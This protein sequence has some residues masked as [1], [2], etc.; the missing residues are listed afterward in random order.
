MKKLLKNITLIMA[1]VMLTGCGNNIQLKNGEEVLVSFEN[2]ELS[3]TA[4]DLF[5][6]LKEDYGANYMIELIDKKILDLKYPTDETKEAYVENQIEAMETAYGGTTKFLETLQSYGYESVEEF[7]KTIMLGYKRELATKDYVKDNLTDKEI[8]KY[9]D[10]NIFGDITASHILVE[11]KTSSSMTEE[12]KREAED[13][14]QETLK[15]IYEKLDEGGNFHDVAIMYSDDTATADNG[16]R[17]GTF[18]KG[19]MESEFEKAAMALEVGKYSTQAVKTSYGYHVIYKEAENKKPELETVKETIIE[20]LVE[21][22]IANDSKLQ[23]KAL[24]ELRKS[25]GIKIN[26]ETLNSQYETAVNNWLYSKED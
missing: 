15:K 1:I 2:E 25:Y 17:L 26:D 11:V 20:K 18:A 21:Q 4:E 7:E 12:Q 23:Y 24:I 5:N 9:Y 8:K 19:E 14:A 10:N 13:K 6:R 16:G 3:I 22:E